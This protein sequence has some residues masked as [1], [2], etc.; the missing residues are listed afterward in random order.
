MINKI[1]N[2]YEKVLNVAKKQLAAQQE[3]KEMADILSDLSEEEKN[4]LSKKVNQKYL[5]TEDSEEKVNLSGMG[6]YIK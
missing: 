6:L 2:K 4:E 5:T 1:D 3:K